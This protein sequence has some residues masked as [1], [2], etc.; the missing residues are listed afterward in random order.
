[1]R[2]DRHRTQRNAALALLLALA[3]LFAQW[4]GLTHRIE[5]A[6]LQQAVAHASL[7]GGADES[8]AHHS[9]VAFDAATVADS[10]H[11]PP[12]AAP[13]LASARVLALWTAFTS[14]DAPQVRHF[15]PRAPPLA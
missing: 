14:W 4:A 3:L 2:I 1:M 13:L 15:S 11:V 10:I 7:T 5:H 8:R 9:C 12:F 6:Q